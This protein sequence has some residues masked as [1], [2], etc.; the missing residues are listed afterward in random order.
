MVCIESPHELPISILRG[1]Q[2]RLRRKNSRGYRCTDAEQ[3][4][5]YSVN[6]GNDLL[7]EEMLP[8]R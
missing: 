1:R 3:S 7:M 2:I 5:E 6:L 8:L 4:V